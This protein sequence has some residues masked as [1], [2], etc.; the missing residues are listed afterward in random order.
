MEP[1]LKYFDSEP[2]NDE[3]NFKL[4]IFLEILEILVE[5]FILFAVVDT[6]NM[7][8]RVVIKYSYESPAT[9]TKNAKTATDRLIRY[10]FAACTKRESENLNSISHNSITPRK[11]Y[12]DKHLTI[13]PYVAPMSLRFP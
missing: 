6:D 11:E 12:G 5:Q 2:S 10:I 13:S 8:K 4:N 1:L 7:G 9:K 3:L